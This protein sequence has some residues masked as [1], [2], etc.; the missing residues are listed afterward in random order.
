MGHVIGEDILKKNVRR[1]TGTKL[2]G[3]RG[4][5]NFLN[6]FSRYL[7]HDDYLIHNPNFGEHNPDFLY[8]SPSQGFYIIEIKNVSLS[9]F[10]YVN[11]AGVFT[12]K[13]GDLKKYLGQAKVHHDELSRFIES[14]LSQNIYQNIGYCLVFMSAT[15][16]EFNNR[17]NSTL[18]KWDD[19]ERRNFFKHVFFIDQLNSQE[20][21]SKIYQGKQYPQKTMN[22]NLQKLENIIELVTPYDPDTV[23]Q[24]DERVK[25]KMQIINVIENLAVESK[26]QISKKINEALQPKI[27]LLYNAVT[28]VELY[29]RLND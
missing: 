29:F 27:N 3:D 24:V 10:K 21:I 23:L 18:S 13:Q 12:T 20:I 9:I 1:S 15:L 8:I 6:S 19:T 16:N 26:K 7:G 28:S 11:T 4:E 22:V 17:F 25:N 5:L 14:T 2:K